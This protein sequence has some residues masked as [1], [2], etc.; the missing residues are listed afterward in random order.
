MKIILHFKTVN[1]GLM[2]LELCGNLR[3]RSLRIPIKTNNS[4]HI[5]LD[6]EIVFW[7]TKKKSK[8]AQFRIQL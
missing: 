8:R 5:F 4:I 6:A 2:F 7:F 3:D 1:W